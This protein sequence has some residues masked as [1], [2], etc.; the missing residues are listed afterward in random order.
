MFEDKEETNVANAAATAED[1][2]ICQT[3]RSHKAI[4]ENFKAADPED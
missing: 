1:Y 4:L 2:F 3:R